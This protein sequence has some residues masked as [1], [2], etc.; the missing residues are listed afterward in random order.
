MLRRALC[1]LPIVACLCSGLIGMQSAAAAEKVLRVGT[2][3]T[4]APFEF[5]GKESGEMVGFDIDLIKALGKQMGYKVELQNLGFDGLIPA[6]ITGNLDA[7]ISGISITP[8]R[9][10]VITFSN[11]YYTAGL[12]I[13]VNEDNTDIK[14]IK[15]L[16]GRKIG[17]QIGTTG[18]FKAETVKN[19]KVV[20]FN[21]ADEPFLELKNKG[22]DAVICDLPVVAYYLNEKGGGKMV[23]EK[24]DAEDFG[25][26]L[27]K[28]N[29]K[30]AK[31][32]NDALDALKKNGE[33]DRIYS[34]W[35]G[36][37]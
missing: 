18:Q 26:A 20:A 21:N 33:Y 30:L 27:P 14:G 17:V 31:E 24:M 13:L 6:I 29:T 23:G 10:K 5:Q 37:K 22:V 25:I 4:F 19:A 15:D 16:E 2:N 8:K 32:I 11:P 28:G 12:I 9:E 35:F 3:P 1:V 34:K 7:A 36:K